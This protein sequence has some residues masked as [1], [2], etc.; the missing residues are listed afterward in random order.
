MEKEEIHTM[1]EEIHTLEKL[2]IKTSKFEEKFRW[3]LLSAITLLSGGLI[4]YH[5]VADRYIPKVS[6]KEIE[7]KELEFASDSALY[8]NLLYYNLRQP[9]K[10]DSIDGYSYIEKSKETLDAQLAMEK[11]RAEL[12]K[13][14]A[15]KKIADSMLMVPKYERFKK[16][17]KEIR[18]A[19]HTNRLKSLSR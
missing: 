9:E 16:N 11:T 17:W 5:I 15:D 18:V 12:D 13:L 19:Y 1:E 8:E 3:C 10:H 4:F 7:A 6:D 2:K 14:K